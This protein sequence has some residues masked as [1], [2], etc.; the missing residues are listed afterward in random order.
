[1]RLRAT[2][3]QAGLTPHQRRVNVRG[4]FSVTHPAAVKS[5]HILIVDDIFTTGATARA[6]A[7]A[8]VKAGAASVWVATL[9][10]ARRADEV[11]RNSFFQDGEGS[12]EPAGNVPAATLQG[13]TVTS[14]HDQPSF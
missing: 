12:H 13:S 4:A 7:Q 8:L 11:F 14:S 5:K 2:G 6:A 9:A 10:R 1:M 3:S